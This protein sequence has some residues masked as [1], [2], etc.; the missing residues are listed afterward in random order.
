MNDRW[1]GAAGPLALAGLLCAAVVAWQVVPIVR[2]HGSRAVGDGEHPASYGFDLRTCL[3]DRAVLVGGKMPRDGV[4]VLDTPRLLTAAGV[5]SLNAAMR[6]KYLVPSDRVIG[7]VVDG[8]ARAYPVRVLCWHEVVNDTLGGAPIAVA[9]NPLCDSA[10]AFAVADGGDTLRFGISGLLW[11]SCH[12][13]YDWR[14]DRAGESLWSPLQTR[15]VAGPAA[16]AGRA[17]RGLPLAVLRWDDWRR[18][19]P[20]TTVVWPEPALRERYRR[21][22]YGVYYGD[23]RLRFPVAPIPAAGGPLLKEPVVAV[24]AGGQTRVYRLRDLARQAGLAEGD[25]VWPESPGGVAAALG[26]RLAAAPAVWTTV[27]GGATVRFEVRPE[28]LTVLAADA[29]NPGRPLPTRQAFWFAWHAQRPDD[30]PAGRA[31]G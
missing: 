31:G 17:L 12:L 6:G 19:Q 30:R 2:S 8:A 7:V 10:A 23:E 28:P 20:A 24:E 16:A 21:N 1:R 4:P 5:D 9:Y 18:L 15:A 29:D 3:V 11:N 25:L 13:L 26:G 22:P 14:P 27:Q